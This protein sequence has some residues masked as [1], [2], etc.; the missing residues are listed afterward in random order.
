MNGAVEQVRALAATA[1][2]VTSATPLA[3]EARAIAAQLDAPLRVAIAGRVKAGKSTLLNALVGERLAPTDAGECT[4]IVTWYREGTT[5]GV[6]AHLRDGSDQNVRFTR[7]EGALGVDLG[8]LRAEDVETLDVQWPSS[9]LRDTSLIDTPG[10]ASLNDEN[11]VRTRDFL[12]LDDADGDDAAQADAV[13]YLMRHLHRRDAD[14]LGSFL[15]RSLSNTSPVNAIAVLSRADEIGAGRLDALDS[16]ARIAERYR[17]DP[18]VRS[19]CVTVV[20]MAGLLAETGLTLA[21]HEAATLR[22]LAASSP[23]VVGQMLLSA[24]RFCAPGLSDVAPE[25]R[26]ALLQR[27]GMFGVRFCVQRLVEGQARTAADLARALV[28]VSG[29]QGLRAV[30][31]A[32]FG[33]RARILKAR[34]VLSSL[35]ALAR[36]VSAVDAAAGQQLDTAIERVEAGAHEFAQMRALHLVLAGAAR[37]QDDEANEVIDLV[38]SPPTADAPVLLAAIERWRTRAA[39]PLVDP[40]TAEVCDVVARSYEAAYAAAVS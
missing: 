12:A 21:E 34:S 15:D 9:A 10:L 6:T 39:S 40:T 33:A 18:Q 14:F 4:R 37:L 19:L 23:D 20:P 30:L 31:D 7:D 35:R 28:E 38:A 17:S 1:I 36:R 2:E 22:E 11:S 25:L 26:R 3:D 16:A 24:D 13:I 27:L 8:A 5:Y 29:L 32:H